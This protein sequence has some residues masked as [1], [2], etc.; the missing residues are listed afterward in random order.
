[1]FPGSAQVPAEGFILFEVEACAGAHAARVDVIELKLLTADRAVVAPQMSPEVLG[2]HI[3]RHIV[4]NVPHVS[5]AAVGGEV[6]DPAIPVCRAAADIDVVALP[7][8]HHEAVTDGS[9]GIEAPQGIPVEEDLREGADAVIVVMPLAVDGAGIIRFVFGVEA[10]EA[11]L[12][13]RAREIPHGPDLALTGE[14]GNQAAIAHV[15]GRTGFER[16][17]A[18]VHG[19]EGL[20]A[21]GLSGQ[22]LAG[23][24]RAVNAFTGHEVSA[25]V[26]ESRAG[27]AGSRELF[28]FRVNLNRRVFLPAGDEILAVLDEEIH[29]K[30]QK[31]FSEAV[32]GLRHAGRAGCVIHG[33]VV[34]HCPGIGNIGAVGTNGHDRIAVHVEVGAFEAR[35]GRRRVHEDVFLGNIPRLV[36]QADDGHVGD[37]VLAVTDDGGF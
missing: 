11:G 13:E 4:R 35:R 24:K 7:V 28:G 26:H 29:V 23:L 12:E 5:E 37:G 20:G 22:A 32:L 10:S 19:H 14:A 31:S 18:A 34:G 25:F 2:V 8:A 21:A 27:L 17:V 15:Y 6:G 1:M 30:G 36:L 3:G 9:F 16:G 33:A